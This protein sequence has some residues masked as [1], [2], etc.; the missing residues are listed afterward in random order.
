MANPMTTQYDLIVGGTSGTPTRLAKGSSGTVLGVSGSTL[1]FFQLAT[2]T[3]A[4]WPGSPSVG[5][6]RLEYYDDG[7]TP[8]LRWTVQAAY[9]PLDS[10]LTAIAA[11]ST[12][13]FGRALLTQADAAATRTT[14]GLGTAAT[15]AA[16]AYDAA[17]AAAAAQAA[18]QPLDS[19]LTAIA[20]LTTTSF[21]RSF[22][23]LA[24]A[25]A[26]RTLMGVDA[27]GTAVIKSLFT[28]KGDILGVTASGTVARRAAGADGQVLGFLASNSDG[29]ATFYPGRTHAGS[30]S[31]T[32]TT[33]TGKFTLYNDTGRSVVIR[34][35]RISV[36]TAPT[37][38]S[39]I[40][41][42]NVNGS[43]IFSTQANRPTI[44]VSG[45]TSGAVTNMNT[46]A[47]AN[48]QYLTVDIDQIGSTI[49]GAD[50]TYQVEVDG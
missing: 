41:D 16:S 24:D 23:S 34:S 8:V 10:D 29:L 48:A 26:A 17:G 13:S 1:Q 21:G 33:G 28:T 18:S 5:T 44:A 47:W 40:A 19:D 4:D 30:I 6:Y 22:L 14:L 50:L 20:A 37:G 7:D 39:I 31:G 35:V 27:S 49:A 36:T 32:I 11:L 9:Q 2:S 45:T 43:T 3:L 25:A 42:F 12:T 15:T 38:S 46:T